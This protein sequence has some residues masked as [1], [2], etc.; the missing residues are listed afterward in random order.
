MNSMTLLDIIIVII[1]AVA[2][3]V[4]FRKGFITQIGSLAAIVIAILACRLLGAQAV[5]MI[6]PSVPDAADP[7]SFPRYITVIAV[8][9]VIYLVAYYAVVLVAKLLKL[10]AHTVLLG[11]L[12]RIGGA[13]VSVVK[14]F[15]PVS[16]ALNLYIAMYPGSDLASKSHL[17]GGRPVAWIVEL[18]PGI[19]GALTPFAK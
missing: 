8:Y 17:C 5:E 18:A 3:V 1:F 2:A 11:P 16:L 10:V 15:I 12:D 6:S 9:C 19:L 7:N 14:W 13:L 4:G